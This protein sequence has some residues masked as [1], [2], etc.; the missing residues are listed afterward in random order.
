M[1]NSASSIRDSQTS[2]IDSS[3]GSMIS[4]DT[5]DKFVDLRF[6]DI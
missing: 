1:E 5:V 2:S 4:L 6:C 3:V